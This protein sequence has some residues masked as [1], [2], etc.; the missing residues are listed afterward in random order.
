MMIVIPMLLQ[1]ISF[2][3]IIKNFLGNNAVNAILFSGVFFIIA[4]LLATRLKITPAINLG[5][6]KD[7]NTAGE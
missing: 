4:A 7:N 6:S 1:T 2:G 5:P 3:F